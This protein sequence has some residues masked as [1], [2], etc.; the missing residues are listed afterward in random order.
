MEKRDMDL[1]PQ[2]YRRETSAVTD[3]RSAFSWSLPNK[4]TGLYVTAAVLIVGAGALLFRLR[5][6]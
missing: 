5:K 4:A 6:V 3:G 2:N 1:Y